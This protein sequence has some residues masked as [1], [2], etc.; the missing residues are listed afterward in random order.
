VCIAR[1][2]PLL[3]VLLSIPMLKAR[4]VPV[5]LVLLVLL[6]IDAAL[7]DRALAIV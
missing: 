1:T 6:P 4:T 3:T 2:V 5:L 7:S